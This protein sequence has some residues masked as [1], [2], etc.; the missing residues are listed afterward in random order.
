M[1]ALYRI[2]D[3][4]IPVQIGDSCGD[5][6]HDVINQMKKAQAFDFVQTPQVITWI[7]YRPDRIPV[8]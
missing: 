8:A 5:D 1:V 7:V 3:N 4:Q 2:I 6:N